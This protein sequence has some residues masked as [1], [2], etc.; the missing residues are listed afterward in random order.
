IPPAD[1]GAFLQA[2]IPSFTWVGQTNNLAHMMGHYHHTHADVAEALLPKSMADY[3]QAAERLLRSV[4][5]MPKLPADHRNGEYWKI[6]DHRYIPGPASLA[7]HILAFI[8]FVLF[9]SA[10]FYRTVRGR[11]RIRI[12]QVFFAEAKSIV[13]TLGSLLLGYVIVLMLPP[14][15]VIDQYETYP[16]TQKSALLY[17][18]NFLA[19]GVVVL[20]VGLVYFLLKHVFREKNDSVGYAEIRKS[21]HGIILA[22]II[23]FGLIQNSWLTVLTLVPPAYLWV[24]LRANRK[25]ESR[26]LNAL[27]LAGGAITMVICMVLLGTIFHIGAVY[28]YMFLAAA[29]GLISAYAVVVFM[30]VVTIMV[31]LFR[32]F[33]W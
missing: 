18:P 13:I 19:M 32:A 23:V 8:P 17:N 20:V 5:E 2:G 4:D 15:N 22:V 21:L 7:L 11:S 26:A 10:R 28:W 29:Y 14:L 30:I 3:G 9:T 6:T 31:R 25:V 16:A 33:V 27:L 24:G 1:N 12:R